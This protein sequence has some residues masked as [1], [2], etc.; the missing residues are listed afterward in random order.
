MIQTRREFLD[1]FLRYVNAFGDDNKRTQANTLLNRVV[2][3]IWLKRAWRQFVMPDPYVLSTVAN[4]RSY[5]LPS[6]FG[7]VSSHDRTIKNATTG[8][9]LQ[10]I[11]IDVL[12]QRVPT[13]GTPLE[14]ANCPA[15]YA[16]SGLT[17]VQV[18]PS[19]A[20][21][22][23]EV[24]SDSAMDVG[25]RVYI[26]GLDATGLEIPVQVT[27]NGVTPV[28]VGT[29]SQILSFGKSYAAG[30]TPTTE[31]TTS[32]GTVT[33]R[34]VGPGATLQTLAPDQSARD[35]Q[36]LVLAPMPDQIYSISVPVLRTP[37]P[38]IKDADPLP[39]N[40]VPAV[41]DKMVIAW[42]V[43]DRDL[44]AD[45]SDTWPALVDLVCF[46]NAQTAVQNQRR[47]PYGG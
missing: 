1:D 2:Q 9:D 6:Y 43:G 42:R 27:L 24:L 28:A 25:V 31:E 22:A 41:F 44:S 15:Y 34:V 11:D 8:R 18:Q 12:R 7:R 35:H 40:W 46:D 17:P 37:R 19:S 29:F 47:R 36:V 45:N 33:L 5:A 4:V 30:T 39:L 38:L 32:A 10:P 20:G 26:E 3:T 23:L 16:I 21:Q 14:V 13:Q